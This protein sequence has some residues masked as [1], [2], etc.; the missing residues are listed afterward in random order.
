MTY[1]IYSKS[2]NQAWLAPVYEQIQTNKSQLTR[3]QNN[4]Y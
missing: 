2:E 1:F 4:S 3:L